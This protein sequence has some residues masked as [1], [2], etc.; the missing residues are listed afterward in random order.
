M[1]TVL[2]EH[3]LARRRIRKDRQR[4]HP[5]A[6]LEH[7]QR[8]ATGK[9][10]KYAHL[11]IETTT[12]QTRLARRRVVED[13]WRIRLR[14]HIN[15]SQR[16]TTRDRIIDVHFHYADHLIR[17][18]PAAFAGRRIRERR[19]AL[20]LNLNPTPFRPPPQSDPIGR[21]PEPTAASSRLALRR[22]PR[23]RATGDDF[24][25]ARSVS[26][27]HNCSKSEARDNGFRDNTSESRQEQCVRPSS[28][29]RSP[30]N[31]PM[32]PALRSCTYERLQATATASPHH[33]TASCGTNTNAMHT[34]ATP[35]RPSTNDASTA[36]AAASLE[37]DSVS[38]TPA[39]IARA[40]SPRQRR[41]CAASRPTKNL[42]S[43]ERLGQTA[44]PISQS[45]T[46]LCNTPMTSPSRSGN[47]SDTPC[48][49]LPASAP[50]PAERTTRSVNCQRLCSSAD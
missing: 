39:R 45:V 50:I 20:S 49:D 31:A 4:A 5:R 32:S 15:H 8:R 1:T 40:H 43:E 11:P 7:K 34:S 19:Q 12:S 42:S 6:H 23:R 22:R 9:R 14:A 41:R 48:R 25:S 35:P 36:S 28:T 26:R 21:A 18:Q 33:S 47:S 29:S 38:R 27:C 2:A 30:A 24:A 37:Y 10:V 17:K 3:G 13:R 16:R 44:P 46:V